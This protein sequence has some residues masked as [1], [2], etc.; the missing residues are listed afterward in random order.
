LPVSRPGPA[1]DAAI[2]AALAAAPRRSP[3]PRFV[4]SAAWASALWT[5]A[6]FWAASRLIGEAPGPASFTARAGVLL[7]RACADAHMAAVLAGLFAPSPRAG[8]E[9]L[10]ASLLAAV[11]FFTIALPSRPHTRTIGARS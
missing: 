1:F 5:A 7:G 3:T 2:L 4:R 11:L 9:F 6:S 8:G 10:A